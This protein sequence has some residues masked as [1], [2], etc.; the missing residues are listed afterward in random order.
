MMINQYFFLIPGV[1]YSRYET[2]GRQSRLNKPRQKGLCYACHAMFILA[3]SQLT[4]TH[5]EH[6][7]STCERENQENVDDIGTIRIV[8]MIRIRN[9]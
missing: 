7:E 4:E 6:T 9:I 5:K 3:S 2:D 1:S 8:R